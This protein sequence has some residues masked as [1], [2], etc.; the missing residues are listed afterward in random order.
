MEGRAG[1]DEGAVGGEEAEGCE[2]MLDEGE[3]G[4]YV[5]LVGGLDGAEAVVYVADLHDFGIEGSGGV[6]LFEHAGGLPHGGFGDGCDG[7]AKLGGEAE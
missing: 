6:E 5:L 1:R 3:R 2:V 7:F 4:G